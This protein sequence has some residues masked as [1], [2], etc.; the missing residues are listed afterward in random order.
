MHEKLVEI[1]DQHFWKIYE[2][3]EISISNNPNEE[4]IASKIHKIKNQMS[5]LE[6]GLHKFYLRLS[7]ITAQF[8]IVQI[9]KLNLTVYD[10]TEL[11][12]GKVPEHLILSISNAMHLWTLDKNYIAIPVLM[13]CVEGIIKHIVS[14]SGVETNGIENSSLPDIINGPDFSKFV[15]NYDIRFVFQVLMHKDGCNLWNGTICSHFKDRDFE[16]FN[17]TAFMLIILKIILDPS[18]INHRFKSHLVT[19]ILWKLQ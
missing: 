7:K 13:T 6:N 14:N 16:A 3:P 1:L 12:K 5:H 4:D 8:V 15:R 11:F 17:F 9:K 2:I 10:W 18:E 19:P